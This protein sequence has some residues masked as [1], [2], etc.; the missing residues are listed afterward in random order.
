MAYAIP[1][2]TDHVSCSQPCHKN[3]N[4]PSTEPGTDYASAYG[5]P[6]YAPDNGRV[7]DLKTSNS[8]GTGRYLC[9]DLDDGRRTRSLHLSVISASVGQ[10]VSRGQLIGKTGASGHGSD[11]GYGAHVHQ[12]LWSTHAYSF[13]A[14][15]TLDFA[16]YVGG[17]GG[18][19]PAGNQRVVGSNPA[20]GRSDP[21]TNNPATQQLP[22][23]TL[24]DF[25]GWINGQDVQGNRVWFRGA[26]SGDW[27]WSG[28]FTDTGTHDLTDLNPPPVSGTQR[29]VGV[30]G[31][32]GRNAPSSSAT[33]TQTLAPQTVADMNGWTKGEAVQGNDSWFRGAHSGDWFWSGGFVT[34]STES[35]PFVDTNPV[36]PVGVSRTVGVNSANVR[37]T[38]YTSAATT[39]SEASGAVVAM[40]AWAHAEAVGANDVWYQRTDGG[41]MWSGGF[42][43][44]DPAGLTEV[45]A[46]PPSTGGNADNP[47]GLPEYAP[48]YQRAKKGLDAPLGYKADGTE[49]LRNSKG[50]PPVATI[51]LIDR[52]I[53]H[54]TATTADQL[55]YFSYKNDR[56]VCPTFYLRNNGDVFEMIRPRRKPAAT[57]PDWNY[58]SIATETQDK[59]GAPTWEISDLALEEH[60]QIAAWLYSFNGKEL[61]GVRVSFTLDRTH[62]IGHR[63][64][65]ATEC[66]GD[67]LYSRIGAII[68]RAIEISG[69]GTTDPCEDCPCEECPE[70]PDPVDPTMRVVPVTDLERWRDAAPWTIGEEI[71]GIIGE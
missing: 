67:Y 45:A 56:S 37:G 30:N 19:A 43:S 6:L 18:G 5:S 53:I 29:V 59:T 48:V 35:L 62:V 10:R 11:W 55:D 38:P 60:A 20:N 63:D 9:I 58:R 33:L 69:G 47:R 65:M 17:G 4:P 31:A 68:T 26:H 64:A 14:N 8:G 15:A 40:K 70:C 61:D 42:T 28:G 3:R 46:P 13:G 21:S 32:N 25:N 49:S 51:P 2:N 66:P 24:A 36:P 34:Q 44:Q 1:T 23:G 27:F 41:W 50:S 57:G 52:Y 71:D 7:V 22:P 12:T 39:G 16:K 54:H